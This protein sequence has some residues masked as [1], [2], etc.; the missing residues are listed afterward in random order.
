[1]TRTE[2]PYRETAAPIYLDCNATTPLEP[3]VAEVVRRYMEQDFGNSANP[4]H[5]YGIISRMAVERARGDVATLVTARSDEAVLPAG[6]QRRTIWHCLVLQPMG[7]QPVD[8][9]S[10]LHILNTGR[11]L[12]R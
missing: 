5:D 7:R 4:V 9:T 8:A 2:E 10:F 12:N 11:Y 6:L 1:V 3:E